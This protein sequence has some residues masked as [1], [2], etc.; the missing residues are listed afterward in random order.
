MAVNEFEYYGFTLSNNYKQNENLLIV[1]L[2]LVS[3]EGYGQT[4]NEDNYYFK[5]GFYEANDREV[6]KSEQYEAIVIN[7]NDTIAI[8]DQSF[9]HIQY[10]F[11]ET[12]LLIKHQNF[13][14][15]ISIYRYSSSMFVL[16]DTIY[17][18]RIIV[19][20]NKDNKF[21][22]DYYDGISHGVHLGNPSSEKQNKYW[23][24]IYFSQ[25]YFPVCEKFECGK[26]QSCIKRFWRF[27]FKHKS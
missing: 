5:I 21:Y 24:H 3:L 16:S 8:K 14:S 23:H 7:E 9:Y 11:A 1:L 13:K 25:I 12:K 19:P 6:F 27:I 26:K 10:P 17:I 15:E 18:E 22:I 20:L 4:Q 2:I